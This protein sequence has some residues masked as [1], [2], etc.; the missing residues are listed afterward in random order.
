MG[1]H[2]DGRARRAYGV[3]A[4]AHARDSVDDLLLDWARLRPD[5][6]VS[7]VGIVTRMGRVRARLDAELS[8][9]FARYDLTPA[10]FTVIVTLRRAGEPFELPQARLMEALALT[11]GTVSVRVERLL[12]RGVVR[13]SAD[14]A[15]A[16]VSLI[17]L[18]EEG[19]RLFDE[20][21][22]TH[23]ANEERLLSALTS[24]QRLQLAD[25][26]RRLNLDF[27]RAASDAG[28]R[29]GLRVEPAHLTRAR[30]SAVGL[31]D[32][33]GLLVAGV[34]PDGPAARAGVERGDV[35]VA[36]DG[37]PLRST[38]ELAERAEAA[39]ESFELRLVRGN[40]ART[41]TVVP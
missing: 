20:I 1:E 5:L 16:R 15:N 11:S 37:H 6:D 40:R 12:R 14:P 32:V 7:P 26:L 23:L 4:C 31:S 30:R 41:V 19:Q 9:V 8:A 38:V 18:T 2:P 21:A 27:E 17:A 3:P 13:R 24:D 28:E 25:L 22:P 36:W 35:L 33:P 34:E 39:H 29:L 10:D